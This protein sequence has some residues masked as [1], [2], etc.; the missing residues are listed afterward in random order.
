MGLFFQID[1]EAEGYPTETE[2][3]GLPID[4]SFGLD[5][6]VDT[7]LQE[8]YSRVPVDTGYLLGSIDATHD[9]ISVVECEATAEYAQYVEY[10]TYKMEAQPY[11]IP[12]LEIAWMTAKPLFDQAKQEAKMEEREMLAEMEGS[13]GGLEGG[14]GLQA[15]AG[16]ILGAMI[17]GV[18]LF[19]IDTFF[20]EINNTQTS[21][22][23]KNVEVGGIPIEQYVEIT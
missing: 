19:A 5:A 13:S 3:L 6:F 22:N 21:F 20:N 10:G 11:F 1:M 18:V 8:A 9:G 23:H 15:W 16:Q 4:Y 17:M 14:G 2:E 12:A 7:F